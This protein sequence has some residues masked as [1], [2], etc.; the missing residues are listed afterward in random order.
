MTAPPPERTTLTR[1]FTHV[2]L[3][4]T[5]QS[6]VV[7]EL[8]KGYVLVFICFASEAMHLEATDEISKD[9]F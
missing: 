9:C 8:P 6:E 2:G 5:G 7:V 4:F 3:N 1:P